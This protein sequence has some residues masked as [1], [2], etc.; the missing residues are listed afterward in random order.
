MTNARRKR[1]KL[2]KKKCHKKEIKPIK[3]KGGE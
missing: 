1:T 3:D 2:V